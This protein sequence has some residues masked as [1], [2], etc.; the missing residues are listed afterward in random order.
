MDD[1]RW[2]PFSCPVFSPVS[3]KFETIYQVDA[4]CSIFLSIETASN[5]YNIMHNII[6]YVALRTLA[7]KQME[8][9]VKLNWNDWTR[10]KNLHAVKLQRECAEKLT[11]KVFAEDW[12]R[13]KKITQKIVLPPHLPPPPPPHKVKWT[14]PH[15][16]LF[17]RRLLR[18]AAEQNNEPHGVD[19]R[20][21]DHW[22]PP[23]VL[24]GLCGVHGLS[25]TGHQK[26]KPR[27]EVCWP[28]HFLWWN[29]TSNREKVRI[30]QT[31]EIG[32][33]L[34]DASLTVF[35]WGECH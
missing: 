27:K 21:H 3:A 24:A 14:A 30:T 7:E 11:K 16:V 33:Y 9:F 29:C 28:W 5:K 4:I 17:P 23:R 34:E 31:Q 19:C 13:K 1:S 35:R 22:R 26:E 20:L 15:T 8:E 2:R 10:W 25:H 6:G 18:V 12:S 32:G